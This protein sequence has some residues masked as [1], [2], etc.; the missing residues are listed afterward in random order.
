MV[1][2]RCSDVC[3]DDRIRTYRYLDIPAERDANPAYIS[4][5]HRTARAPPLRTCDE[6]AQQA[7]ASSASHHPV[8]SKLHPSAKTGVIKQDS[9]SIRLPYFNITRSYIYDY[10][11][12]AMNT[13][14]DIWGLITGKSKQLSGVK[15][16]ETSTACLSHQLLPLS[17]VLHDAVLLDTVNSRGTLQAWIVTRLTTC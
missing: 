17:I 16:Y 5:F 7:L 4:P 13:A 8:D 2:I 12:A 14:K 9:F 11:H 15:R 1:G 6:H 10:G 3:L